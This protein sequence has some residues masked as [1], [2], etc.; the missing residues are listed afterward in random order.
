MVAN[1]VAVC[2][3]LRGLCASLLVYPVLM[4]TAGTT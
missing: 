1:P 4:V 3:A 2:H